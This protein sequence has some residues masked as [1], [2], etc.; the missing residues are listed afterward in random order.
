VIKP[1]LATEWPAFK[2][3]Y[4]LTQRAP[5]RLP[6][7]GDCHVVAQRGDDVEHWLEWGNAQSDR[8][9]ARAAGLVH[10]SLYRGSVRVYA[11]PYD[12]LELDDEAFEHV[13]R[14]VLAAMSV[15]SPTYLHIDLDAWKRVLSDGAKHHANAVTR[16]DMCMSHDLV[17]FVKSPIE[18]PDRYFGKARSEL[19]DGQLLAFRAARAHIR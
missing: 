2:L 6:V 13:S 9:S 11:S 1:P 7:F 8:E 15:C 3:F 14:V 19:T 12:V 5:A 4:L 16:S 17:P 18:R 10:L